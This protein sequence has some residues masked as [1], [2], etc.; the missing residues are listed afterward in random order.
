M[1]RRSF[2]KIST[3]AA[4]PLLINGIPVSAV[5]RNSFLDFVAPD[6]DKIL[7]LIQLSGGNDGLNCVLPL[8]QYSNLDKVR[9]KILIKESLGLKLTDVTAFHPSMTSMKSLYDDGALKLIHSVGYPNQN[10]SHFRS[11]DIWTSGSAADKVITTGWLGRYYDGN[12]P[13]FPNGYPNNDFPHPLALTVGGNVSQTCQGPVVNFSLAI[14]DPATLTQIPEPAFNTSIPATNYG[15][16]L[17][18]IMTTLQQYNDYSDVIKN[19][20]TNAGGTITDTGNALLNRLNVVAQLIKGGL[21]T[22]VYV[23]NIGGFDTHSNQCDPDDHEIGTHA[24][25]LMQLSD[26]MK[27]F[28][29]KLKKEG[30]EKRVIGMTFSEFGRRIKANDSTGTDHGTA[31]PLF[32]FG[33]CIKGGILGNNP[34][35]S[36]NVDNDEGVAMQYDFRSVYATLLIDWFQID[37]AIVKQILYDDF[38]KLSIIE[39]CISTGVEEESKRDFALN[40]TNSPNPADDYTV[41]GF[42]SK[43]EYVRINLYDSIGSDLK[44]IFA[45]RVSEGHHEIRLDTSWLNSGNYVIRIASSTAQKTKIL[46]VVD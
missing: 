35:I 39:G 11:T 14:N 26:A 29:D 19:A 22:K 27:G 33:S 45:G 23:V 20:N 40:L 28:Q 34:T 37:P 24:D 1:K 42:D 16:E 32:L 25:L 38:Q 12:H 46:S 6:N 3:A 17:K 7:V 36:S 41:I 31:A 18:Y 4:T 13:T 30:L 44:T 10:R 8:D 15:N 9:N 21:K 5:A 43:N 2:L